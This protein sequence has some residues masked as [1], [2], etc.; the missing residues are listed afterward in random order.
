MS[1]SENISKDLQK[2]LN[3]SMKNK[4]KKMLGETSNTNGV[5]PKENTNEI[6]LCAM[7]FQTKG[8]A[9][10]AIQ[11][12]REVILVTVE[13]TVT[14]KKTGTT[15]KEVT[16]AFSRCKKSAKENGMCW[17]HSNSKNVLNYIDLSKKNDCMI[18]EGGEDFFMKKGKLIQPSDR[19]RLNID[20]ILK[21]CLE[22]KEYYAKIIEFA[23]K[24][25]KTGKNK[26][27]ITMSFDDEEKPIVKEAKKVIEIEN[28]DGDDESES[29]DEESESESEDEVEEVEEVVEVVKDEEIEKPDEVETKTEE[30]GV[31]SAYES[32]DDS[33]SSSSEEEEEEDEGSDDENISTAEIE[34]TDGRKFFVDAQMVVYEPEE[35]DEATAFG[36]LI[37]VK[38][39]S[40]PFHLQ[41]RDDEETQY[42]VCGT[43][44]DIED[45]NYW[46]CKLTNKVYSFEQNNDGLHDY[47]GQ[48]KEIT[49]NGKIVKRK[50]LLRGSKSWKN[51][52]IF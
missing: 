37:Q 14:N 44:L 24:L 42:F 28:E 50:F 38:Y 40:A 15:T 21:E 20:P 34:T 18:A 11:K 5:K 19:K 49:K 51:A 3:K 25:I 32:V 43:R 6:C 30:K 45:D 2:V 35:G 17:K 4:T 33:D 31:E 48:Y 47:A 23:K 8:K 10:D 52:K 12:G 13:E 7:K 36:K 1:I 9:R 41:K 29:G 26:P 39:K 16:R 27:K 22:N 46:R